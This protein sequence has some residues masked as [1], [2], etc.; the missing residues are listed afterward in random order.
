MFIF[1]AD[2][3]VAVDVSAQ[4]GVSA[5]SQSNRVRKNL[6]TLNRENKK[7]Q[8]EPQRRDPSS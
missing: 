3:W 7:P 5:C 8:E 4:Q 1:A 6:K 2:D